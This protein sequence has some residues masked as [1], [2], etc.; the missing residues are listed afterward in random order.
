M[1]SIFFSLSI[2]INARSIH[3]KYLIFFSDTTE[4]LKSTQ[5][6]AVDLEIGKTITIAARERTACI[7]QKAATKHGTLKQIQY[8]RTIDE[9]DSSIVTEDKISK[10]GKVTGPVSTGGG[11][12]TRHFVYGK[13]QDQVVL[14]SKRLFNEIKI[15]VA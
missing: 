6:V 7:V 15:E 10:I 8:T 1:G 14:V 13:V 12:T 11:V 4:I 3:H 9:L 5:G 2:S